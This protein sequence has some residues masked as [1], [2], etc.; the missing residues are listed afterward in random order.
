MVMVQLKEEVVPSCASGAREWSRLIVSE[1]EFSCHCLQEAFT[2]FLSLPLGAA[3]VVL[4]LH[5]GADSD[6][7]NSKIVSPSGI[8]GLVEVWHIGKLRPGEREWHT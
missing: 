7:L 6:T 5:C 1:F 4:A 2:D 8:S 3:L